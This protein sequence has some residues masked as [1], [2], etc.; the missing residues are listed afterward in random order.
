MG[1]GR[2]VGRLWMRFLFIS[3]CAHVL[4]CSCARVLIWD[5]GK[6]ARGK[7]LAN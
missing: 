2:V 4:V 7:E 5:R 3:S 6:G 1:M